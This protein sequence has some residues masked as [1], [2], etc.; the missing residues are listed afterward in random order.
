MIVRRHTQFKASGMTRSPNILRLL[1]K[2][3][4]NELNVRLY[5]DQRFL[6]TVK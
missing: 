2:Y 4:A 3:S 1:N 6:L 5:A